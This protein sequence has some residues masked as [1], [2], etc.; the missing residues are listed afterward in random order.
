MEWPG[1]Q[2]NG[3]MTLVGLGNR[4]VT[5]LSRETNPRE[6]VPAGRYAV[7][8]YRARRRRSERAI[9]R[10]ATR[11]PTAFATRSQLVLS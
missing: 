6:V 8:P 1:I 5:G 9:S 10:A 7:S 11:Q 2:R 3:G 4:F